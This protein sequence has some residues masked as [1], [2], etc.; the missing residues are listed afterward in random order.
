M[1]ENDNDKDKP[2]D[3]LMIQG[4]GLSAARAGTVLTAFTVTTMLGAPRCSTSPITTISTT[5]TITPTAMLMGATATNPVAPT[6]TTMS[7]THHATISFSS[8]CT[9]A[10]TFSWAWDGCSAGE[11][12]AA[13]P[14]SGWELMPPP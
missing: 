9:S 10:R 13:A 2:V 14:E 12:A 7:H 8:Y 11:D 6:K 3:P 5:A 1:A 4:M